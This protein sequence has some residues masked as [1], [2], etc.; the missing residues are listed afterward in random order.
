MN[1]QPATSTVS[2]EQ[3][4]RSG[5]YLLLGALLNSPCSE[6]VVNLLTSI[7]TSDSSGDA[8]PWGKLQSEIDAADLDVLHLGLDVRGPL[9]RLDV[10]GVEDLEELAL[11]DDELALLDV[12][13]LGRHR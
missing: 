1:S 4:A 2:E 13:R 11:P 8:L 6:A 3:H 7:E 5:T 10:F 12:G 9:P